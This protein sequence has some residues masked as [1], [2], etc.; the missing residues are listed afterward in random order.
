MGKLVRGVK[1][2]FGKWAQSVEIVSVQGTEPSPPPILPFEAPSSSGGGDSSSLSSAPFAELSTSRV[3]APSACVWMS[4]REPS[5][6]F[7][8]PV[9]LQGLLQLHSR[10]VRV[11]GICSFLTAGEA[12][13]DGG[14]RPLLQTHF[15]FAFYAFSFNT[16]FFFERFIF[17]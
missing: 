3:A 17:Q 7:M 10:E 5:G 1:G 8:D 9:K 16:F 6:D 15:P 14:T 2:A 11:R 13:R 12:R 4:V